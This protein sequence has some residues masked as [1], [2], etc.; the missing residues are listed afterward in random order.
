MCVR[1]ISKKW[2]VSTTFSRGNKGTDKLVL[3]S[4]DFGLH[5]LKFQNGTRGPKFMERRWLSPYMQI[6][7][8]ATHEIT[9]AFEKN[10][11]RS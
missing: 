4:E 6:Q 1:S 7:M 5:V 3:L 8:K 9:D 10:T 2:I 11:L